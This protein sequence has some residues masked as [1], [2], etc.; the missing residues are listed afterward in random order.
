MRGSGYWQSS[1]SRSRY[2]LYSELSTSLRGRRR[3]CCFQSSVIAGVV[4]P[5]VDPAL[6]AP[7][8]CLIRIDQALT[9]G[10][11]ALADIDASDCSHAA[12]YV[13]ILTLGLFL[14]PLYE[15]W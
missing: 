4:G 8:E 15:F 1:C 11:C 3:R 2:G 13:D 6:Q 5:S 12:T 7:T 14:L 10:F 9:V